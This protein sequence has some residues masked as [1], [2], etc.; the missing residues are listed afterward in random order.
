METTRVS[1]G[2]SV[3]L[4]FEAENVRSFRDPVHLSL[5]ATPLAEA[6]VP[7]SVH[8]REGGG[9]LRVLPAACILGANASG[10]SN[11]LRIMDDM[12]SHVLHSFRSGDPKG[13]VP[14][15][16]FRLDPSS[17]SE[18]S[19]FEVDLV[20]NGI[21]HRYGFSID[22]ER[23]LEEWAFHFPRGKARLLF[24]RESDGSIDLGSVDRATGRAMVKLLR[25]N[26]LYLSTAGVANHPELTPLYEWF[27]RNLRLAEASSRS[28]RWALT[29]EMLADPAL[30]ETV[31]A[32]LR[33]ADL[34]VTQARVR[35]LDPQ[36][37]ERIRR[38]VRILAGTEDQPDKEDLEP[39]DFIEL[40]VALS[41]KG[42]REDVEF[43]VGDESLGTLVWLGLAGPVINAL[44]EGSVFLAD[45]L[46][47]SL[48]PNLVCHLVGL[49][50]DPAT[51]PRRAQLIF[52]SHETSLLGH[53]VAD[54]TLG[55]DQVWFTEK[56][57]EGAT[58]LY[59][60]SDLNPRKGEAVGQRYLAG[61]YG[62]TPIIAREEFADLA[63]LISVG[64]AE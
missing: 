27:G 14:R 61:R 56:L 1:E 60:L 3:L 5:L 51:N 24:Q 47:A 39:R 15:Q 32:F 54:R 9:V 2:G 52:N 10:K 19:R 42:L 7:R 63:E 23:V 28:R 64:N 30:R 44:T 8:W 46:E 22:D 41:H 53:S 12:R 49:F 38:A 21:R 18:P 48:H 26:A 31:L 57:R 34:G 4:S 6:N 55:R 17:S 43:D 36:V 35:E 58:R 16:P 29:T 37:A 11:V 13:G 25:P 59:P 50:Q 33:V 20:L 45:E 40:G 62:A